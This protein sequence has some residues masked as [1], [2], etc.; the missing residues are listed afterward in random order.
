MSWLRFRIVRYV[1]VNGMSRFIA[2]GDWHITNKR[3]KSRT[4]ESYVHSILKKIDSIFALALEQN[5]KVIA[6][7]GDFF[8]SFNHVK[9][10][11]C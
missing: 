7:P 3:P 2:T 1:G 6:Q 11:F 10:F 5:I 8:D 4:D 9:M